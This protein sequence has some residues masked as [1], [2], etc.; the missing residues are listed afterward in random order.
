MRPAWRCQLGLIVLTSVLVPPAL[1][2]S[3]VPLSGDG[4]IDLVV[5]LAMWALV[6]CFVPVLLYRRYSNSYY[7]S[8][9]RIE[10]R[11]GIIARNVKSIRISDLRN[12]NM[13]QGIVDRMLGIGTIEFSSAG[14]SGIEVAWVGILHPGAVRQ[15]I[16]DLRPN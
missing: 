5:K 4:A 2:L 14:G 8:E 10:H 3:W 6:I 16:E 13:R 9:R 11:K 12:V 15:Q 7:V 1:L